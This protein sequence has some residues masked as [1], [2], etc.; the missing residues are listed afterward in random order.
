MEEN[1]E[2]N[3]KKKNEVEDEVELSERTSLIK[4]IFII[5]AVLLGVGVGG[6]LLMQ[7]LIK[8][9]AQR[10][11]MNKEFATL[12]NRET[13]ES[14]RYGAVVTINGP[15]VFR[16]FLVPHI[17]VNDV[18]GVNLTQS[19]HKLDFSIK[20]IKLYV[21]PLDILRKKIVVTKI[22]VSGGSFNFREIDD[23]E[24]NVMEV[25][26]KDIFQKATSKNPFVELVIKNSSATLETKEFRREFSNINL[27]STYTANKLNISGKLVSN[28]QPLNIDVSLHRVGNA[29]D[30]NIK[31]DSQAFDGNID[32]KV[33]FSNLT[34]NG[35]GNFNIINTQ[36]F[37]RTIFNP[38]SFLYKRII[39][40]GNI[41]LGFEFDLRDK[42][43]TAN[44]IALDGKS[45]KANG[46]AMFNFNENSEN[47]VNF[48]V[49]TINA[50]SL[51]I[52][53]IARGTVLEKDHNSISIFS[54]QETEST[55]T[56]R[57]KGLIEELVN[58][59]PT[60]FNIKIKNLRFNQ[61]NITN[62]ELKFSYGEKEKFHFYKITSEFPGETSFKIENVN[63][64][65]IID[66][67][68]KDFDKFWGFL[69]NSNSSIS[70]DTSSNT[71]AAKKEFAFNGEIKFVGNRLFIN[72]ASYTTN[73]FKSKNQIEVEFDSGISY[74][75]VNSVIDDLSLDNFIDIDKAISES[76]TL[77]NKMLF[78]N[79]FNL[80][81]FF[82][83]DIKNIQYKDFKDTNYNFI[84]K[85][86]NG[87]LNIYD[88]N[89]NNK[90]K[91][92][93][94]FDIKSLK[95][96]INLNLGI[97]NLNISQNIDLNSIIFWLPT[98]EDFYGN[99]V[100]KGNNINFKQSNISDL[101][102]SL[103]LNNGILYLDK[104]EV[105][106]FGGKCN[107]GGYLTLQYNRRLNI[108]FAGC[109]CDLKDTLYLFTGTNNISGLA[110]FSS[111]LYAEGSNMEQFVNSYVTKIQLIGTGVTIKKFG[112]FDLS[113]D[114][115]EI[116]SNEE[117][118]ANLDPQKVL[119]NEE[120]QT[121]FEKLSGNINYSKKNNG[122][123]A[124][125]ISRPMMNG[126]ISGT[127]DLFTNHINLHGNSSFII[128]SGTLEK[129]IPLTLLIGMSG[130]T[131]D[132]INIVTNFQQVN[133]Y[134]QSIKERFEEINRLEKEKLNEIER[135]MLEKEEAE[136]E[137]AE[138][139]PQE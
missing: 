59:N 95:P 4:K 117:I 79:N 34:A 138:T 123:F 46:N 104:F 10:A 53:N 109:T 38:S 124:F 19:N 74:I 110:G 54:G 61:S 136:K 97:Q 131:P 72:N 103:R 80:Q 98:F 81:T 66:V 15:M 102:V 99:L 134:V 116:N 51:M 36:V 16:S 9:E 91:G 13:E 107:V 42:I 30:G 94:A 82:R 22:E 75:A 21:S 31:S 120:S 11:T 85:T 63:G 111:F 49:D 132:N 130:L 64:N 105:N 93:V 12:I 27:N 69:K 33:D 129:T 78:L 45:I 29:F 115:F 119:Y 67:N 135:E 68:S 40:N 83:F 87:L 39:D 114:L 52:K 121:L 122:Q 56:P 7:N 3:K 108:K 89:L 47:T 8:V 23:S 62:S 113:S 127:F 118:L 86:S 18:K 101:N 77:K 65:E 106:G 35:K 50:D 1:K 41:K 44:N 37:T 84:V 48:E 139:L 25:L 28:K 58:I 2:I 60:S 90:I 24:F 125:D 137:E 26:I 128:L 14:N 100:V 76:D 5:I 133:T 17:L 20:Q 6:L 71:E 43:F 112:L 57:Y 32:L 73:N 96:T 126:K 92:D 70:V 55:E 88:I